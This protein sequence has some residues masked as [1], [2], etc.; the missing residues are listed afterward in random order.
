MSND[1]QITGNIGLYH[2]ARELSREGWN[3]M[4][5]TRNAKGADMLA[6]STDERTMHTI[7]VKAHSAKPQ[8]TNL[9]IHPEQHVT[10]WWV[11]VAFARSSDP[12]CY[13]LSLDEIRERMVR[14]PGSRSQ[15]PE[16]L[17]VFWFDRRFYT[18]GS[19][20]ELVDARNAWHRLGQAR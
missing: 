8:D 7:Q 18:P 2:V 9:G 5:T 13:I 4:L 10:P 11:F 6:A 12:T 20:R 17:R 1:R 3:V 16:H 14:D 19:D 15:K